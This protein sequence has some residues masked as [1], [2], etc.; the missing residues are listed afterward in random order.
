MVARTGAKSR[1]AYVKRL[2]ENAIRRYRPK[3]MA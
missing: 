3:M 1:S 2:V